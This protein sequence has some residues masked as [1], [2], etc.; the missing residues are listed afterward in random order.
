[1]SGGLV[2]V[3]IIDAGTVFAV[4]VETGILPNFGLVFASRVLGLLADIPSCS[5]LIHDTV[6]DRRLALDSTPVMLD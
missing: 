5:G 2:G 6:R 4:P 1:M 3:R